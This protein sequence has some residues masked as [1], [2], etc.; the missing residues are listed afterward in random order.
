MAPQ[1]RPSKST[2]RQ[3]T[4][5][6]QQPS[7]VDVDLLIQQKNWPL[8]PRA[9]RWY[10]HATKNKPRL[11]AISAKQDW[12][13]NFAY[14]PT[15]AQSVLLWALHP[16]FPCVFREMPL[17]L[18]AS[19][20]RCSTPRSMLNSFAHLSMFIGQR[21]GRSIS[22]GKASSEASPRSMF[23]VSFASREASP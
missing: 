7:L 5:P 1:C 11:D 14:A 8:P 18:R 4:F 19:P 2:S 16:I 6:S 21:V 15:N 3:W 22:A 13:T 9:S 23:D 17:A 10:G 12:L 20:C